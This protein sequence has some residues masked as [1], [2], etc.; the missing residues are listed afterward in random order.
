[1]DVSIKS[2]DENDLREPKLRRSKQM[3]RVN[4]KVVTV[5]ERLR[6]LASELG[7]GSRLP[8]IRELCHTF[9]TSSATVTTALDLLENEQIFYR[10]DRQGIFVSDSLFKRS[11]HIV[12]N[13]SMIASNASSPFWSLLWG[14]LVQIAEYRSKTKNEQISF[15]FPWHAMPQQL[16]DEHI[17]LLNSPAADGSLII[18]FNAHT[19]DHVSLLSQPHV[20]FAG[21]GDWMA[22][23]DEAVASRMAA[24][25]LIRKHCRRIAYWSAQE[26]HIDNPS[27]QAYYFYRALKACNVPVDLPL[28]RSISDMTTPMR[29]SLTYQERGYLLVKEI[30]GSS[31]ME[32]PDGIYIADDLVTDGALVAFDELGIHIGRDVEIVSISNVDSPILFGRTQ[33]MTLLEQDPES[34]VKAMFSLLE[35]LM[36]GEHPDANTS[37]VPPRLR[38]G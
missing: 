9:N 29:R 19:M 2:I 38:E 13:I 32:K 24:D 22:K 26:Q 34:L 4:A 36:N 1:M 35:S 30:F 7:P 15:H 18:G 37:Y 14:R 5:C 33:H 16:S 23:Y 10:K 31:H 11:I 20:V 27:F 3:R 28:F 12:F 25:V 8:T 17:A 6:V 21:G